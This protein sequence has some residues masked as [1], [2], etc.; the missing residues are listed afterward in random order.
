MIIK[1][2][3]DK[4]ENDKKELRETG[5]ICLVEEVRN[6]SQHNRPL[7]NFLNDFVEKAQHIEGGDAGD[8]LDWIE[9][10][11]KA[12]RCFLSDEKIEEQK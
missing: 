2:R 3:N 1:K 10:F 6:D 4:N 9:D 11:C 8:V 5:L 7:Y 12:K